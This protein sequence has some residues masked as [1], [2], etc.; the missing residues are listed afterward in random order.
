MP[1]Y[2]AKFVHPLLKRHKCPIF[3]FVVRN[4]VQTDLFCKECLTEGD[5]QF[6]LLTKKQDELQDYLLL[7]TYNSLYLYLFERV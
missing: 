3:P 4:L 6:V 2:E 5:D 7:C 1:G